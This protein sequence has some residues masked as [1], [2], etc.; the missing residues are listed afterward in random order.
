MD[1][2]TIERYGTDILCY[3]LR[4]ARHKKRMQYEDFDKWLIALEKEERALF[5]LKCNLGWEPLTPPVQKGWRRSFVL[6]DDVA[7][8]KNVEFFEGILK[9]INTYQ[10]SHRKDFLMK[11]RKRGRKIYVPRPQK[12]LSPDS[13]HF[14]KLGF[15]EAEKQFFHPEYEYSKGGQSWTVKYVFNEPGR[16]VLKVRP[17]MIDKVRIR[18]HELESRMR[19]IWD[20]FEKNDL[21]GR[22]IKLVR[23]RAY[24]W[25]KK[26]AGEKHNERDPMKNKPITRILDELKYD[27]VHA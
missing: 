6:R 3:R 2:K 7:R 4:T 16:F 21:N 22:R 18:D 24:R 15:N 9:K 10:Y 19:L 23:G 25:W 14:A 27:T 11:R 8:G 20:Y 1:R 26:Y 5:R 13:R 12:L 17:N